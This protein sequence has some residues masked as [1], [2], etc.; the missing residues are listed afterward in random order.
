MEI[1]IDIEVEKEN[2]EMISMISDKVA[3]VRL[4]NDVLVTVEYVSE[5]MFRMTVVSHGSVRDEMVS[6]SELSDRVSGLCF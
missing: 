1:E 4:G 2:K 3:F 6:S 5:T